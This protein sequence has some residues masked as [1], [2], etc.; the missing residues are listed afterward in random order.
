MSVQLNLHLRETEGES[1]LHTNIQTLSMSEVKEKLGQSIPIHGIYT[2]YL[3]I[4]LLSRMF[5]TLKEYFDWAPKETFWLAI[6]I[7]P[8]TDQESCI[9]FLMKN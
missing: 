1:L 7:F 9:V 4:R 3:P 5:G 8:L 6:V 2:D